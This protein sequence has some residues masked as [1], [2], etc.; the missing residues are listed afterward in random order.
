MNES[1]ANAI[2]DILVAEC[3]L[4]DD[5]RNREHFVYNQTHEVVR[6][7]RFQGA[8]GFGGK[9]WRSFGRWYVNNYREDETAERDAM[10][11]KATA[12]LTELKEKYR[13]APFG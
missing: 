7:W 9:F 2:W 12:R 11:E 5:Q 10:I 4:R 3:G 8:L 13:P 1:T 6:E